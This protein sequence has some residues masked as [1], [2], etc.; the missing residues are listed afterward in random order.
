I[1]PGSR[2]TGLVG[3]I[4][5]ARGVSSFA[6]DASS[7]R[8][9][10]IRDLALALSHLASL[11]HPVDLGP[12]DGG[13][14]GEDLV[15][16]RP[17]TAGAT[18]RPAGP[19]LLIPI[20]GANLKPGMGPRGRAESPGE[21]PEAATGGHGGRKA[22]VERGEEQG[23]TMEKPATNAP[24]E[25]WVRSP[26]AEPEPG[27][28]RSPERGEPDARGIPDTPTPEAPVDPPPIA[29][30]GVRIGDAPPPPDAASQPSVPPPQSAGG[31]TG[32]DP[33]GALS[34]IRDG[35]AAL[36][37]LNE[38]TARL[39]QQ[40]LE[41]QRGA[42]ES[43]RALIERE[44]R[45]L[46]GGAPAIEAVRPGTPLPSPL[47]ATTAAP[48]DR[49]P[50][51]APPPP[52]V[53]VPD[54]PPSIDAAAAEARPP[55]PA[56][57]GPLPPAG[58]TP[59]AAPAGNRRA[60]VEEALLETVSEKTGYPPEILQLDMDLEADLG[61]DS[62]KR[63]EILSAMKERLPGTADVKPEE[64]GTL[65]TLGSIVDRLSASAA[66]GEA[67]GAAPGAQPSPGRAPEET[68]AP[69]LPS[70]GAPGAMEPDASPTVAAPDTRRELVEAVLLETVAQKTGYPPEILQ[71]DMDLEADLGID[72][73]KRVEILSAM[74]DRL[75][76]IPEVKPEELGTLG[77]LAAIATR[78]A[79]PGPAAE[80]HAEHPAGP[81]PR[82]GGSPPATEILR[83]DLRAVPLGADRPTG[84]PGLGAGSNVWILE[85]GSGLAP[86]FVEE[87]RARRMTVRR[88]A[89]AT[90]EGLEPPESLGALILLAPPRGEGRASLLDAFRLLR[91]TGP[92]LRRGGPAG[93]ALVATVSRLDGAFGLHD[94][95][96]SHDPTGGG[97]SGI[98]K[99]VGREW[100]EVRGRAL[101]LALELGSGEASARALADE[102]LRA[103]PAEVGI[104]AEGAFAL[105][106]TAARDGDGALGPPFEP[107]EAVL[108]TGGAR[109][110]TAECA[111]ALAQAY[112]PTLILF[113]RSAPPGAA[114]E[115]EWLAGLEGDAGIRVAVLARAEGRLAPRGIGAECRAHIARREIAGN[116]ARMEEAGS[117]VLYRQVDV[118]ER[119]AVHRAIEEARAEVGPIRGLLHGAG[120][121][122]DREIL[123]KTEE[124]F[125][126]VV[127]TKVDSLLHLLD[128]L[129][130]EDLRTI[131]LFSSST[132]RYGRTGQIDY[133]VANEILNKLAQREARRRPGTRVVSINWGPWA[134]GMV[135]AELAAIFEREGIGLIPTARGAEVLLE[136]IARDPH[137]PVEVVVLAGGP[138]A[139]GSDPEPGEPEALKSRGAVKASEAAAGTGIV[140]QKH[141]AAEPGAALRP[142]LEI[143]LTL[144][145]FPFLASHVM[146][147]RAVLPMAMMLEWFAH[148]ALHENPGL[149]FHGVDDLR[150]LKGVILDREGVR[151]LR[152]LAGRA[153]REGATY[154]VPLEL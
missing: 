148:A 18:T 138:S 39:H 78:L 43:L 19:A 107:G 73:I 89:A 28:D 17:A 87:L 24:E 36:E 79:G 44:Q 133:A 144:A 149:V 32:A 111:V 127:S 147:G 135:T 113:G 137:A 29:A 109:G 75:P 142:A 80:H 51:V 21:A 154:R 71:L 76:E 129:R 50:R 101:D 56:A 37:R 88:I 63:V 16:R 38:Q 66:P 103:G 15:A 105:E 57:E 20:C 53:A 64:L 130:D 6:L 145:R 70:A 131:A 139:T 55:R 12:W 48:P 125:E 67:G 152:F 49:P 33:A 99:T 62:I 77:T 52:A 40:F 151:R 146:D 25:G 9:C 3:A 23:I 128:A 108:L 54:S 58:T 132:A 11:G 31:E 35:I 112:R 4:T 116:I 119:S 65:G 84:S 114:P 140:A 59:A 96:P 72:S 41:A 115:P 117:R 134:G 150:V 83:T 14:D 153:E 136:E 93:G 13:G 97:F 81:P 45:T 85:D 61:I 98:A 91:L 120:V 102:L 141:A 46:L 34:R 94:L 74:R 2:L 122:A 82:A 95:G 22:A 86:L 126:R 100:P 90:L 26:G 7:G 1:C 69:V 10:G 106:E 30:P 118:R 124:Q 104:S 47:P 8:A 27:R 42:Q 5:E 92:A 110:V 68:E 123:R 121:I 60:Q 143:E